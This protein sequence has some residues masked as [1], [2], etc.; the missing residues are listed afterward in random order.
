MGIH[1]YTWVYMGILYT[2]YPNDWTNPQRNLPI[3]ALKNC[4]SPLDPGDPA[5][6][7]PCR[8][9]DMF[10]LRLMA[11]YPTIYE[12]IMGIYWDNTGIYVMGIKLLSPKFPLETS[13][14]HGQENTP[15][16]S[17]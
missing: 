12:D 10:C 7:R 16:R 2:V 6:P 11:V 14:R 5:S 8:R 4:E 1:G 15:I 13:L 17:N 3:E 9:F